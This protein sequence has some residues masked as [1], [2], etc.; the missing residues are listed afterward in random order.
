MTDDMF[1]RG[2]QW[3]KQNEK[4]EVV[5]FIA[6]R[7]AIAKIVIAWTNTTVTRSENT[8]SPCDKSSNATWEWLWENT[9]FSRD[10]LR[11]K[12]G[13]G[14]YDFDQEFEKLVGN[15]I[16]YPD[17]TVH[18]FV[19]KYLQ[20]QVLKLFDGKTKRRRSPNEA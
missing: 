8:A 6:D 10:E 14:R 20:D 7:P 15:H 9:V 5:L 19:Q 18:S 13:Q 2:L 16:L 4:P 12:S 17:G 3:F 1:F 11:A